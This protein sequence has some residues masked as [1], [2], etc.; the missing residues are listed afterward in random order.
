MRNMIKSLA[1]Y[2]TLFSMAL[3]APA[4]AMAA[5]VLGEYS[6]LHVTFGSVWHLFL[7]IF[8]L[9]MIPFALLIIVSWRFRKIKEDDPASVRGDSGSDGS[10]GE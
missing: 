10:Q 1:G 8:T 2:F 3:L 6:F 7:F 4:P 5:G 9:V